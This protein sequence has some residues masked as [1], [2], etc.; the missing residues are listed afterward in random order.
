MLF[1]DGSIMSQLM[2]LPKL[3]DHFVEHKSLDKNVGVVAFLTMHYMGKDIQDND[4]EKD[5]SLPFKTSN[6]QPIF[7]LA[8]ESQNI[9]TEKFK[10]SSIQNHWPDTTHFGLVQSSLSSL[11]RPP[12]NA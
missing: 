6:Y 9:A 2:K 4:Q 7:Q 3:Y 5:M 12:R 1:F 11:F 8:I 10:F